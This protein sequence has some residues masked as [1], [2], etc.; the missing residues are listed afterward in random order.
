M[1]VSASRGSRSPA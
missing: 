1:L